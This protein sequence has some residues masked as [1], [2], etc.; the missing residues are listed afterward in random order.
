MS[1]IK[2]RRLDFDFPQP[3]E[4]Y[5]F[6]QSVFKTHLFNSLTIGVYDI[7]KYLIQ[8]VKKRIDCIENLQLQQD[9]QAFIGQEAQ[10]SLQHHKFWDNLRSLGYRFDTYLLC[11]RM[12]FWQILYRWMSPN[13]NLAVSVGIEHLTT[14]LAEFALET[15]FFATAEPSLKQ[16]FEWHAVEELEH[17]A[18]VFD[19]L[20]SKTNNYL[21]RLLGMFIGHILIFWFL[22]LGMVMFLYQDKKLLDKQVWQE[23]LEFWITKDK[24]LYK[25][26]L[27]AR[28][29]CRTDFHPAQKEHL[30]LIQSVRNN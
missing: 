16:M 17:K 15:H 10:H 9:A 27:N 13:F 26:L 19:V 20:Q 30:F 22:N 8:N 21:L 23:W 6:N 5:W 25:V 29:F 4:K 2:V 11:L 7:E 12:V 3:I 28:D 14:L 24:F 1:Q 18:V